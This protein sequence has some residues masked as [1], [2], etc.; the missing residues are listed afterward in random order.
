[1]RSLSVATSRLIMCLAMLRNH[2]LTLG[3]GRRHLGEPSFVGGFRAAHG[4]R[5]A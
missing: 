5:S 1:M 3:K 2:A 4:N